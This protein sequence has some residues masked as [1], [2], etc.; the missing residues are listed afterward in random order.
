LAIAHWATGNGRQAMGDEL[1]A[2]SAHFYGVFAV[3]V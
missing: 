2:I 3:I 1:S